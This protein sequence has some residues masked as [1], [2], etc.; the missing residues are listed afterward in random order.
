MNTAICTACGKQL[1]EIVHTNGCSEEERSLP[2]TA[3]VFVLPDLL[4]VPF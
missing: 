4:T 2:S 1:S 3:V